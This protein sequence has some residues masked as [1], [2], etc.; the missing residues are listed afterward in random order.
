MAYAIHPLIPAGYTTGLQM[1]SHGRLSLCKQ[2]FLNT[3]NTVLT[4]LKRRLRNK[5]LTS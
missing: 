1:L 2:S 4:P 3:V 5:R